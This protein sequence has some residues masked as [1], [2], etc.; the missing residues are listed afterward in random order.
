MSRNFSTSLNHGRLVL[1]AL[2]VSL[3]WAPQTQAQDASKTP[4]KPK[5]AKLFDS[6]QT[7]E[8]RLSAPWNDIVRNKKNQNPYPARIEFSDSLGQS[9]SIPLTVQRR[10]LTRQTVCKFPPVKLRFDKDS[11]KGTIFSGKK[12]LKLVTHCDN[13]DRWEQYY[14]KEMLA[15]RMYNLITERSF[16]VRP[17]SI[18]YIDSEKNSADDPRFAFLIED[19]S[20]VAK[21]NKLKS[22][23][24]RLVPPNRLESLEASRLALFQ[25]MI[26]NVD[27]SA[28]KGP[29]AEDCCHNAKLIGPEDG[30]ELYAVPYDF[31][32][33]GLVN[34]HYAVPNAG[35]PIR[36]VTDRLYRG[37]CVHNATLGAARQ[38]YLAQEQA[39]LG[40]VTGESR[41]NSR[42][43]KLALRY[44]EDFF[45]ILKS[46]S[47]F[48][49]NIIQKCRR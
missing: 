39:V 37:Y 17:L 31:D 12:S 30:S 45:D 13:G 24:I 28:L 16:R 43:T 3:C 2:M 42:I 48:N 7:M 4:G 5:K 40:L 23:D 47:E 9:H 8:V 46:D 14:L 15:Y 44:L 27:Y 36:K 19:D 10:G 18:T 21:R 34:A 25:Y 41:L 49:K 1:A 32:V 26:G 35:L 29:G 11:V 38:E 20:D 6:D 22:F 33:S